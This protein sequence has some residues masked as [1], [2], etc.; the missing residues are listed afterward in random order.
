MIEVLFLP[1]WY[2]TKEKP[3]LGNFVQRHAECVSGLCNL[4]VLNLVPGNKS[5]VFAEQINHV[6]TISS[7]FKKSNSAFLFLRPLYNSYSYLRAFIKGF[8]YFKKERGLPDIVHVN[9]GFPIGIFALMLKL[10]YSIPF[11]LTEHWSGYLPINRRNIGFF[12]KFISTAIIRKASVIMPVSKS[13]GDAIIQ[14]CNTRNPI[15]IVGNTFDTSIFF[16]ITNK[17]KNTKKK[18]LHIS[19]LDEKAKNVFGLLRTIKKLSQKRNDFELHIINEYKS[20]PHIQLAMQLDLLDTCVF[21]HG[22]MASGDVAK[23]IQDADFFVLFSNYENLPVVL[24]E[25]LACGIPVLATK[26]GG[27]EEL[28]SPDRG[29]LIEAGDEEQLL[30]ALEQMIKHH[31]SYDSSSMS[32]F[33]S[34]NFAK[35]VIGRRIYEGYE[36]ALKKNKSK[37][38]NEQRE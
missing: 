28:I 27:I 25:S 31:E 1:G 14:F 22:P 8:R 38:L 32:K 34:Q 30:H 29:M 37:P 18:L 15:R 17:V 33:A 11:V 5:E 19:T 36:M 7:S 13:L 6:R 2:P 24:I 9:V 26:V 35:D 20:E 3:L 21:F 10:F 23:M 12:K 4:T 16:P